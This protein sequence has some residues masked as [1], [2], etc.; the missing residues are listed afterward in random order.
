[1]D[2]ELIVIDAM[3]DAMIAKDSFIGELWDR[4][5]V[6]ELARVALLAARKAEAMKNGGL[7]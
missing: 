7:K 5:E 1:M 2:D 6:R 4:D 3:V